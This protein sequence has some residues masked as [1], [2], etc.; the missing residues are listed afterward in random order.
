MDRRL[1]HLLALD[2]GRAVDVD[3]GFDDRHQAVTEN[4]ESDLELLIDDCVDTGGVRLL[5]DRTHLGAEHALLDPTFEQGIEI[6]HRLH[7]LRTVDLISEAL[8]ALEERDDT[9]VVPQERRGTLTFDLA[10]HGHLEEDR[11]E[12]PVAVEGGARDDAAPHGVDHVEH[13]IVAVVLG[14]LDAVG[15]QR[16]RGRAATLIERRQ[17][18]GA[19]AD[20]V[21]HVLVHVGVL[22]RFLGPQSPYRS[23]ER[24]RG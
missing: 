22:L 23:V 9:L 16:L 19:G 12:D 14:L 18:A 8:V 2:L 10:I 6:R 1:E 5:D 11:T 4:L 24:R 15:E 13:L 21:E 7:H 20:L 3:L 17:E